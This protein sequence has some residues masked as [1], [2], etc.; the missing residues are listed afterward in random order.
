MA[1]YL[2]F[3]YFWLDS[4]SGDSG[5]PLMSELKNEERGILTYL[6]GIVSF[7]VRKCGDHP[8]IYTRVAAY[9]KFVLDNLIE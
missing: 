2:H 7:G 5:G 6:T 3:E 4:C 8:A 9:M 1:N